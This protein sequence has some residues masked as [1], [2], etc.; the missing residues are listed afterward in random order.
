MPSV[1]GKPKIFIGAPCYGTVGPEILEDWMRFAYHCGRRMPQYIVQLGIK[2]KSEQFRARIAIVEAALQNNADWLLMLDDDMIINPY[3]TSG[4]TEEYGFL[5]KMIA[6]DKDICGALYWQRGGNCEPVL[7]HKVSEAGYRFLRDDELTYGLQ[8][9]AVAG[10]G[11][12]L[13]KMRVFDKIKAPYFAPEYK[14]STDIQLCRAA[15][16]A[17]FEVWADTSI[18]LGHIKSDRMIVTSLNRRQLMLEAGVPGEAK[19]TM[20]TADV[21]GR[22]ISDVCEYTGKTGVDAIYADAQEYLMLRKTSGLNDAD[23]YREF[24]RERICRQVWYNTGNTQKKQMTEFIL[25]SAETVQKK[26]KVLDFGCGIG[27]TAFTLAEKGHEVTAMDIRGTG[28]LEFLKWRAKKH[29]VNI[30]FL[31]S[32]GGAPQL[33]GE[34][35]DAVVAMDS[36]EHIAQ[37]KETVLE[38]ARCLKP[39]GILFSNNGILEDNLHP[40]HYDIDNKD[41]ISTCMQGGLMPI[42][43]IAFMKK[44]ERNA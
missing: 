43:P 32:E 6:H 28:T 20:I 40:E 39:Q 8:R 19:K 36:I 27:I 15:S 16:E 2:T 3:V 29:K 13:I 24:P 42:N 30:R 11:C 21:Y 5:E 22:L 26:L 4:P 25:G 23:W 7:M 31:E 34:L 12:L 44:E 38:L 35:Y 17:G 18:E 9:V 33:D 10:G 14:W 1:E 41:F 37:W